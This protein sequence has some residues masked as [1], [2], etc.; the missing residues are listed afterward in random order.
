MAAIFLAYL[1]G[2]LNERGWR[3][4]VASLTGRLAGELREA[5]RDTA[6]VSGLQVHRRLSPPPGRLTGENGATVDFLAADRAG[7]HAMGADLAVVDEAGLLQERDR[8]LW[9]SVVSCLGGRNGRLLC[10]SIQGRGPMF[11]EMKARRK[12]PAV[13]YHEY[14]A[15]PE[16][17]PASEATWHKAN[18]GLKSGVKSIE[19][20]RR[21][22]RRALGA[23][24]AMPGFLSY[25]LNMP[26]D[27]AMQTIVS[28][29]EWLPLYEAEVPERDDD[30]TI[31][32]DL[33][34]ST[35]M[36]AAALYFPRTGRLEVLSAF[37]STPDLRERGRADGVGSLYETLR[38][39]GE[40]L[41]LPG[42]V[43]PVDEFLARV[44]EEVADLRVVSAGA[45]RFRRA[46]FE[47]AVENAGLQWRL[48]WRGSGAHGTTEAAHDVRAFQRAVRTRALFPHRHPCLALESAIAAST[49]T[50][51]VDGNPRLD[52]RTRRGRIDPLSA[53]VIAC[54]LGELARPRLDRRFLIR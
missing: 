8:P 24:E 16:D 9:D 25:E 54:G 33:G 40:L 23:P 48:E 4:L 11:A 21:A 49:L 3:G 14:A 52:R 39:T 45:D 37:P 34:G 19:H 47:Q 44:G 10:I 28:V 20:M 43:T 30:V 29:D 27:P 31:G 53:T 17:D 38:D 6:L 41:V 15:E 50:F 51:D 22:A 46:E 5:T 36:T 35:S 12:D 1:V 42:R 13:V 18:P 26:T 7:A 32:V 2:P